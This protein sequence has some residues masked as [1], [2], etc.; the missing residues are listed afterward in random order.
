MCNSLRNTNA[1]VED[2]HMAR[3]KREREI[4]KERERQSQ[5]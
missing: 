4:E 5:K 2:E 3:E 1:A